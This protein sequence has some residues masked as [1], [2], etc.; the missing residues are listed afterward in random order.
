VKQAPHLPRKLAS[1]SLKKR[2]KIVAIFQGGSTLE[3]MQTAHLLA[4]HLA[5]KLY[6]VDIR[7]FISHFIGE[8]EKNLERI[9]S[10]VVPAETLLYFDEADVLFGKT[11]GSQNGHARPESAWI[12]YLN[13]R[14]K[15]FPGSV[16]L[17][18]NV[19][20]RSSKISPKLKP[21]VARIG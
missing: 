7:S 20:S 17:A 21:V 13:D 18:S 12:A 9:F 4:D 16:L 5:L 15:A 19:H 11:N 10:A 8:T 14:L 3:R 1:P 6:R 2:T